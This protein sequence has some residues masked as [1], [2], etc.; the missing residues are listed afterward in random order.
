LTALDGLEG[1]SPRKPLGLVARKKNPLARYDAPGSVLSAGTVWM[2][3]IARCAG[4]WSAELVTFFDSDPPVPEAERIDA[5]RDPRREPPF[6]RLPAVAPLSAVLA[7]TDNVSIALISARVFTDGV[8]FVIERKIRRKAMSRSDFRSL[9]QNDRFT[10]DEESHATRLQYGVLLSDG[11]KLTG[12]HFF[13][14]E[15]RQTQIPPLSHILVPT[16]GSGG[17]SDSR[18]EYHDGLWLHPLPPPGSIDFVTQ[19][20]SGGIEETHTTIDGDMILSLASAVRP[21]WND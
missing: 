17:G 2:V 18:Y 12:R 21:L 16:D 9:T 8:E 14:E 13:A 5:D 7:T 20:P 19:W 15:P 10:S 4:S 3:S 6:D 1:V 11:Q